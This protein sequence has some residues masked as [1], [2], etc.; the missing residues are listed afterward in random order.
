MPAPS[1]LQLATATAVKHH[2]WLHDIGNLPY[3]LV[4]PI[5]LKIDNPE[6]LHALEVLS[7][8]IAE[9]DRELWLEFIKRDI[10][11]W[12]Q[13]DL[14]EQTR[15]WYGVYRGLREQV[16]KSLDADAQRLKSA[17]DGIQT[18]RAR[19]E[20]KIIPGPRGRH[21]SGVRSAPRRRYGPSSFMRSD[22]SGSKKNSIFAPQRRNNALAI[23]TKDLSTRA[24]QVR[25][26]PRALVEEHRRPVEQAESKRSEPSIRKPRG[27]G[28]FNSQGPS[29]ATPN[30]IS[31]SRTEGEARLLALTSGKSPASE[32]N[33]SRGAT[34][35]SKALPAKSPLKRV[36]SSSSLSGSSP[37]PQSS[38]P[39]ASTPTLAGSNSSLPPPARVILPRKKEADP[40]L[41]PKKR[42]IA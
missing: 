11:Q 12:E 3:V 32:T 37:R 8:Q 33:G 27:V 40:F 25:Q 9:A 14:P 16:Q 34:S 20:P 42:R 7:P 29:R 24:S 41:R 23:P 38:L 15:D 19:L 1:L 39:S 4:R 36:A 31:A 35:P 26:A 18:E 10:P 17:I 5:L 30:G 21:V 28:P 6:K 2:K 13:Y 22:M